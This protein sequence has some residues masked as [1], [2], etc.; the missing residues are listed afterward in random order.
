M[1][2]AQSVLPPSLPPVGI[3]RE[4]AAAFIGVS[5]TTFDEMVRDGRMPQPRIPSKG[6]IIWDVEEVVLAFRELP[7]R[8]AEKASTLDE[9]LPPDNPWDRRPQK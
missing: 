8:Q 2:R 9:A 5:P 4:Q 3:N 6:R 1:P 7:H